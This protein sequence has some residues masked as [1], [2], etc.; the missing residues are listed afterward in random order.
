VLVVGAAQLANDLVGPDWETAANAV[1]T[2]P[3]LSAAQVGRYIDAGL[4]TSRRPEAPPLIVT[5]DA[6]LIIGHRADGNLG[7][8]NALMR[9]MIA[10]GGPVLTSWEA[11]TAPDDTDPRGALTARVRPAVWPTPEI[12][13]LINHYRVAAGLAD[14][15]TP[16]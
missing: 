16:D 3:P 14:R 4:Y 10:N 1:I 6:A 15:G 12:L 13:R 8:I 5:V 11:W 7:R 9:R 2:V